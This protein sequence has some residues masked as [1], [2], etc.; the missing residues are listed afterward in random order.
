M[1]I[2]EMIAADDLRQLAAEFH[3]R[4]GMYLVLDDHVALT[5]PRRTA[6]GLRELAALLQLSELEDQIDPA[7]IDVPAIPPG[8]AQEL[9][10][11]EA[12]SKALR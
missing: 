10:Q 11:I 8:T 3:D 6:A 1:R 2:D 9:R 5:N 12:L 7:A 4:F